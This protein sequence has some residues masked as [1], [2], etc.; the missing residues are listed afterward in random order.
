MS[1]V[2]TL[3]RHVRSRDELVR[4]AAF[5]LTLSRACRKAGRA[6]VGA[7]ERYA[8][9]LFA[10]F[11][12]EP[13]LIGELLKG[14]LGPHAEVDVLEQF[15]RRLPPWFYP[16]RGCSTVSRH[17]HGHDWRGCRG[18]R[19]ERRQVTAEDSWDR[20]MRRTLDGRDRDELPR[21]RSILPAH[22]RNRA[23]SVAARAA[24]AARRHRR[25]AR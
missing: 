23:D 25:R 10:S 11:V 13:Q 5:Q 16:R 6:L 7:G 22:A 3:Y 24:P 4:L 15:L 9:S 8:E 2:P 1:A 12:A 20:A 18:H 19:P 14:R 21:V 17:R